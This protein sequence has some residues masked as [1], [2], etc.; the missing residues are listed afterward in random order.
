MKKSLVAV[1]VIVAL[2]VVWTGGAWYTGKQFE[3]HV[4]EM[5]AEANAQFKRSAPQA[6]LELSYQDYQ[7]GL[8]SSHLQ[9]V[10]KPAAG[11]Q[12]ALLKPGQSVV[13][14]QVV[15]HGPFPLADLK[16]LNILPAMA[17]VHTT[18]VNNDTTK[19]L[20]DM[21]KGKSFADVQTRIGYGGATS[22]D[23]QL[24]PLNYE[25]A[26]EK[27]SF[28]GGEFQLDAD[29]DGN[30]VSL[31]GEASSGLVSA[32]NEYGQHVQL[33]FNGLKADGNTKMTRFNERVGE[34]KLD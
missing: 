26:D 17:S 2:G 34:Q 25:A 3:K 33:T 9:L 13:L 6:G 24:Q 28:S 4:G 12:E 32:V 14:E 20:F 16:K 11:Q 22:S 10:V 1:G 23:I 8:F 31:K 7:R 18:L 15:S 5:V 21:A 29:K 30:D 27:V 19:A